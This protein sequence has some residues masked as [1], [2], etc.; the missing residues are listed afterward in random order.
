MA[1]ST[2]VTDLPARERASTA[3][4]LR[5]AALIGPYA[6]GHLLTAAT[7]RLRQLAWRP[8]RFAGA[9]PSRAAALKALPAAA[10]AGYRTAGVSEVNFAEMS[11]IE[12]WDYPV[13]FWLQRLLGTGEAVLDAG[14]HLGTKYVAFSRALP[15][16]HLRWTVQDLPPTVDAALAAQ[17][18]GRVPSAIRFVTDPA[19]A[20]EVGLLLASGLL[21]YL[22]QP[23]AEYVARLAAPPPHILLN[24][25]ALRDGPT[26]VTLERIG[27]ARVPYQIR[28]RAAFEAEITAMGYRI[29]DSWSI[30]ALAHVIPSHPWLGPSQSRGYLL[31]RR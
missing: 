17:A 18:E 7:A 25:V 26:R 21:Q 13:L 14:G 28:D 19:A 12:D 10:R 3:G 20:G 22:D 11:K 2:P 5:R 23:F 31:N 9:Y 30:A 1:E 6:A 16:A 15:L 24:K 8:P 4:R 27:P 29:E